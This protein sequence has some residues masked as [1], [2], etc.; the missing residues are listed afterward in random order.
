MALVGVP[1][2][3]TLVSFVSEAL[4][5]D[6]RPDILTRLHVVMLI[7]STVAMIALL[8]FGLIGV[9]AG[10]SIGGVGGAVYGLRQVQC[11]NEFSAADFSQE[12]LPAAAASILMAAVLLPLQ[13]FVI[14]A[15]SH[16]TTVGLLL[17][18]GE[19]LLGLALYATT[20]FLFAPDTIRE[21]RSL[22]LQTL[23]R[24]EDSVN[25]LAVG[26]TTSEST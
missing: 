5:A 19:A 17:L 20:L 9:A 18:C 15:A 7:T 3:G 10:V 11:L 16:G 25:P 4:K 13:F 2:T 21:T 23:R 8:P 24:D 6:G 26:P 1:I 12:I 14:D 22:I